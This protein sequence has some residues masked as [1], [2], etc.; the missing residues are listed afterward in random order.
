M[1]KIFWLREGLLAGRSGPNLDP[2]DLEGFKNNGFSAILS[3]NDGEM[4]HESLI[5]SLGLNYADIPMSSNAPVQ[6][7]DKELC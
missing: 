7:G 2:W 3:V 1:E 4:V 5:E 6:P